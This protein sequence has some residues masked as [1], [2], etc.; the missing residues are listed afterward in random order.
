LTVN[1]EFDILISVCVLSKV[2]IDYTSGFYGEFGVFM[3]IG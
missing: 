2:Q 3:R 1:T